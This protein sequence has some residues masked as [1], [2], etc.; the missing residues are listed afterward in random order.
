[1]RTSSTSFC[2]RIAALAACA[3]M[4]CQA[5]ATGTLADVK[6]VVILM[7]E[8]RSF[9]HYFGALK[10]VRG[11]GDKGAL[12]MHNGQ[13]DFHQP[14]LTGSELPFHTGAQCLTDL[15]H[16]W[17]TTHLAWNGGN[18]NLWTTAKGA[19]TMASY[20]RSDLA[21]YYAL[22]DAYTICD[23]YH[24]SVLG[25]TDPNRLYLFTGMIDPAGTGGGPVTD[26]SEPAAGYTWTTYPERLQSAGVSW[27]VYQQTNNYDDNALAWFA[28]Y[29]N[30]QP[31]DPLYDRAMVKSTDLVADF[32]S[33]IVAGTLPQVSWIVAPDYASEH[34][35]WS[36]ASGENITAQLLQALQ[37][38]PAVADSTVFL[39]TYDENDG[40]FDHMQP[41]VAP[42]GTMDEYVDLMPIGLGVRV[43]MIIVSPWTRGGYA[44]SQVFDHTSIIRFLETWTGVQEPNI[45]AWR[46]S[47]CGDLTSAFDFANPDYSVPALPAAP[48]AISCGSGTTVYPPNQQALPTQE[49]GNR[50]ARALPYQPNANSHTDWAGTF[51]VDMA[52]T[53][54]A[55]VHYAIY[56][57]QFRTD[58]PW[59]YDLEPGANL[60]DYFHAKLYGGGKYDLTCYGPNGF[61]RQFAGN[62]NTAS[63]GI[64]VTSSIDAAAGALTLTMTNT[65]SS[66]V[67]FT[68]KANAYRTDGPWIYK[69][70]AGRTATDT[71]HPVAYGQ[72][73]Y[74]L[75]A[76]ASDDSLFLRRLVGHIENGQPSVTGSN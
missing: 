54:A 36:A 72:G 39:L 64:E 16:D 8:N 60:S 61:R 9:D 46:R 75:S 12:Q 14:A 33:D 62:L 4:P 34:P 17:T 6:H 31:G 7:Q 11:F 35:Y 63:S 40:F 65:T 59:Q 76:T 37:S 24:A 19:E 43:P 28:Q 41:P 20:N 18:W 49:P 57:N 23:D 50:P 52:N 68:V 2:T 71:W 69:V 22:A 58:G 30:A 32:K 15:A 45:S 70:P 67:T 26:N 25:P 51:W 38:N 3:W 1:M 44:D 48:A 10:G 21:Y 5:Q 74:D 29:K 56:P 13:S 47:V 73:W 27:K 53:G 55:P 42:Q 66:T